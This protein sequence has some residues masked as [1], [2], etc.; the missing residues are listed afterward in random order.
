MAHVTSADG[1]K[2]AYE[3][4]GS[5]PPVILVD[6]ALGYRAL[7]FS[8]KLA[9][10]LADRFTVYTYDRRGRGESTDTAPYA[11]Q[12]EVE[13][14]EA[15]IAAAGGSAHVYGISS[16]AALALEA[17]NRG[18]PIDG[19]ALYEIPFV[20]DDTRERFDPDYQ[21]NVERALAAEKPGD[22]VKHFMRLVGVPRPIVAVM[23]L[24]PAWS[25]L[26]ASAHTLLYDKA[27]LGDTGSGEPVPADRTSGVTV[28]TLAIGGGK[29]PEWLL[30]SMVA[31]ANAIPT[32]EYRTLEGQTHN[33]KAKVLAP[34]LAEF[35]SRVEAETDWRMTTQAAA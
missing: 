12:R 34:V 35:F 33:V 11:V 17:A 14:I 20:V 9:D 5:G 27:V 16:G 21:P 13:D 10:E 18:L 22:A 28:P 4:A 30:N 2:I 31:V 3:K 7:G 26:K 24:M 23:P 25:K 6:G 1:T 29:S 8:K 19:L 15:L 32:A